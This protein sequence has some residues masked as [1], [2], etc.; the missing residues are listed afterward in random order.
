MSE[1]F[2]VSRAPIVAI[3]DDDEAVRDA[4]CDLLVVLDFPCRAFPGAEEF[5]TE[6]IPGKFDCLITDVTM[7]GR[8]GLELCQH[9]SKLGSSMP[10]IFITADASP[11]TRLRAAS[12]GAHAYLMK[13]VDGDELLGH[14]QSALGL[15]VLPDARTWRDHLDD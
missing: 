4:L 6:F 1:S 3:V 7:P 5:M 12:C 8:S 14:L 9:L 13:P 10:V 11:S 15:R 2:R